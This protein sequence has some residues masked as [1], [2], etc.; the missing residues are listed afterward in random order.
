ML[1]CFFECVHRKSTQKSHLN[2]RCPVMSQVGELIDKVSNFLNSL[3]CKLAGSGHQW[4]FAAR[5]YLCV[6]HKVRKSLGVNKLLLSDEMVSGGAQKRVKERERERNTLY[7]FL[8]VLSS[9]A[10]AS[11]LLH[12]FVYVYAMFASKKLAMECECSK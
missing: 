4:R 2:N 1:G 12:C 6:L 5:P 9:A 3:L 10:V 11:L 7:L 8:L